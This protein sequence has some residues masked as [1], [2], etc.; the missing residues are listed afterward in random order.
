[1][2]PGTPVPPASRVDNRIV[3]RRAERAP[4]QSQPGC[5]WTCADIGSDQPGRKRP[6]VHGSGGSISHPPDRWWRPGCE[7]HIDGKFP[8]RLL[9]HVSV[10][11]GNVLADRRDHWSD[12]IRQC[13]R[14]YRSHAPCRYRSQCRYYY[15]YAVPTNGTTTQGGIYVDYMSVNSGSPVNLATIPEDSVSAEPGSGGTAATCSISATSSG[16]TCYLGIERR[17][18]P[19]GSEQLEAYYGTDGTTWSAIWGSNVTLP[20]S[21]PLYGTANAG[22]AVTSNSST[23]SSTATSPTLFSHLADLR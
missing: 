12:P 8:R 22:I 5:V 18:A 7:R 6:L 2:P 1:M 16:G 15:A 9:P 14:Q 23:N 11:S 13:I 19:D 21:S 10:G 3:H 17:I 20:S 4:P